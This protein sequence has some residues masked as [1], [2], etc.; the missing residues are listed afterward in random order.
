MMS[1]EGHILNEE[2]PVQ[3]DRAFLVLNRSFRK[4]HAA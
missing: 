4:S 1:Q 2:G 3:L